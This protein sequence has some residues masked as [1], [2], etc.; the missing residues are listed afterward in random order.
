MS[1]NAA[2]LQYCQ[3]AAIATAIV[4]AVALLA[5]VFKWGFRFRLIGVT[6]FLAVLTSGLFALSLFPL[7]R[8]QVPG[9]IRYSLIYDSS[10]SQAVIVVPTT[11][12]E[13]ELE[14]TLKQAASDLFTPG[15]SGGGGNQL[16]I[17]ARTLLH[18]EAGAAEVLYIGQI[19]RSLLIREDENMQL[20]LNP[21]NLD[22]LAQAAPAP[23]IPGT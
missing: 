6:G 2:F 15:R 16:T 21:E 7:Q 18:P 19:K 20:T 8:T 4:G 23:A 17:R 11:V 5:F 12:T 3:W 10:G 9:A 14:A 1:V 22:R 13:S